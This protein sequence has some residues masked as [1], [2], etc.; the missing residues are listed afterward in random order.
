MN[1][2]KP[3][4]AI[5]PTLPGLMDKNDDCRMADPRPAVALVYVLTWERC[6][7]PDAEKEGRLWTAAS[8]FEPKS[9]ELYYWRV[10]EAGVGSYCL[11]DS[12]PELLAKRWRPAWFSS[13]AEAQTWCEGAEQL[14]SLEYIL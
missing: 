14:I 1:R 6:D 7:D 9:S 11:D 5:T 4:N 10:R 2:R 8:S 3:G 12:D 13:L